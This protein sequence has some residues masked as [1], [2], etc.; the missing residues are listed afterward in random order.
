MPTFSPFTFGCMSLGSR[1]D[2]FERDIA[3]TRLAMDAGVW[4]HASPTYHRGFTFLILRRA[5][6]EARSL[7]PPVMIKIRDLRPWL[8][9]FEVE[10]TLRRLGIDRIDVAQLVHMNPG[11][12]GLV[13][14][15]LARG[16]T[17][18][19]CE[20][21][22]REGKV[23]EFF[24]YCDPQR[25]PATLR[26]VE[27][28]LFPGLIAYFNPL[29]RDFDT[30]LWNRITRDRLPILALRTLAGA[31][32]RTGADADPRLARLEELRAQSGCRDLVEFSMRYAWSFPFVQTTIGGTANPGHLARFLELAA[33]PTPLD[34]ALVESTLSLAS[35]PP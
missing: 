7:V 32:F 35:N 13:A 25:S 9:R 5:F 8:L 20:A 15:L 28:G 19:T 18:A 12:D 17:H 1:E 2:L 23:G 14:D 10:D 27:H 33:S 24:L 34:P 21:L 30:P 29:Q 31:S 26:A 11:D 16:E 6:D 4:F 3:T 22:R